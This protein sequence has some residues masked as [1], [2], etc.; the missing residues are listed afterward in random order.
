MEPLNKDIYLLAAH[1]AWRESRVN[2]P[3]MQAAQTVPRVRV[4]DLYSSYP[5]YVIDVAGE[6]AAIEKAQ[7]IVLLHPI[8]WYS[9][10]EIGRAHV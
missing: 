7:L 3:M 9:M 10:P 1:P 8:H 6:Q 2:R 5:D 4:Q